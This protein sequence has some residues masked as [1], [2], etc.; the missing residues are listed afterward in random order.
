MFAGARAGA[1]AAAGAAVAVASVASASGLRA[2]AAVV[3]DFCCRAAV[4]LRH[5]AGV[6]GSVAVVGVAAVLVAAGGLDK[7]SVQVTL[8]EFGV[9]GEGEMKWVG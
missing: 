3:V 1:R 2:S 8:G 9:E 4:V 6:V 5:G 7:L